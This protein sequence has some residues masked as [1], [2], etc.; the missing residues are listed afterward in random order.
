MS[1]TGE[2][3]MQKKPGVGPALVVDGVG[4]EAL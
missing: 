4:L 1:K 3:G 2:M